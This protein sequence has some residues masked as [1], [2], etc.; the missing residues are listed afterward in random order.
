M[1][2]RILWNGASRAQLLA[3]LVDTVKIDRMRFTCVVKNDYTVSFEWA[4]CT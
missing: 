4:T 3:Q 1:L 2:T